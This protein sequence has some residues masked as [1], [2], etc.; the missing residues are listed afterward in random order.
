MAQKLL[1]RQQLALIE[2]T[3]PSDLPR[4]HVFSVTSTGVTVRV[5]GEMYRLKCVSSECNAIT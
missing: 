2:Y 1:E 5:S 4:I 3:Y